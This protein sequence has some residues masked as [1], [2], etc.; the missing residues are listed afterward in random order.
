M[1]LN[2]EARRQSRDLFALAMPGGR[3]DHDK[4]RI[5]FDGVAESRPRHHIQILKEILRLARMEVA[6]THALVETATPL[7]SARADEVESALRRQ[8]GEITT[9]FRHSPSLIGG[10]RV[11]IG[12]DVWDGSIRARLNALKQEL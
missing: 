6:R 1:K 7:A 10:A 8:F 9:E 4:L 12:S 2:S 3:L 11:Q 5:V